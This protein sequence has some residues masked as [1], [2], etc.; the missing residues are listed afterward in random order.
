ML[1][2]SYKH[3]LNVKINDQRDVE[4]I[5]KKAFKRFLPH[6]ALLHIANLPLFFCRA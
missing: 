2:H 5:A 1:S 3:M 4:H 6:K